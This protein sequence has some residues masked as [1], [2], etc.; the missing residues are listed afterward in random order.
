MISRISHPH[1]AA[2][3][4][5]KDPVLCPSCK[6]SGIT[7]AAADAAHAAGLLDGWFHPYAVDA[8]MQ[9]SAA[10]AAQL[11]EQDVAPISMQE[12]RLCPP[13]PP[14]HKL[15]FRLIFCPQLPLQPSVRPG[16]QQPV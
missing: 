16:Q 12:L 8:I 1:D 7:G 10:N 6:S 9:W 13:F 11:Q 5:R 3:Q 4:F 15:N 2:P 14:L